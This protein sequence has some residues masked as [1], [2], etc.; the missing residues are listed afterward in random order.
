MQRLALPS[1]ATLAPDD[2]YLVDV[3]PQMCAEG[4]ILFGGWAMAA[5]V[6]VAQAWSGRRVRALA[7]SFVAPVRVGDEL[8]MTVTPL[9]SGRELAHCRID[10]RAAGAVALSAVAMV[11]P[12]AARPARAWTSAPA[13]PPPELCPE[14]SY[15]SRAP[16]SLR[17]LLDVR[18]ASEEP[19]PGAGGRSLLWA[20]LLAPVSPEA[21][22]ALLSDHVPYLVIR[23]MPD[24]SRVT[25]VSA[26]VRIT[27]AASTPWTLLD[28]ELGSADGAFCTGLLRQWSQEGALVATAD[29]TVRTVLAAQA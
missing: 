17:D 22:L 29:Q 19:R 6:E 4:G 9:R 3:V 24:V 27:G 8:R 13:A 12:S 15:R 16:D 7:T 5:M 21:S 23:S 26:S 20:R 28:I 14:R 1:G 11:G 18:L 2:S 10:G 25:S